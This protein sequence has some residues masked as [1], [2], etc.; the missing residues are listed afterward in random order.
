MKLDLVVN[1]PSTDDVITWKRALDGTLVEPHSIVI[2]DKAKFS[3]V[4]M[5]QYFRG[6]QYSSFIRQLNAYDFTTVVEGGL[7][8]PVYTHP[9]FRQ[10][11]RS[12]LFM[13]EVDV[14]VYLFPHGMPPL[15]RRK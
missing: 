6:F 4:V 9:Y 1:D 10:D 2:L 5:P 15:K 3:T 14:L 12:L 11:D 8:P 13:I 7:D